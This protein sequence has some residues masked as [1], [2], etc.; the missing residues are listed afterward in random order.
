MID[1]LKGLPHLAIVPEMGRVHGRGGTREAEMLIFASFS[2]HAFRSWRG[3]HKHVTTPVRDSTRT[4]TVD[5]ARCVEVYMPCDVTKVTAIK[6]ESK[7]EAR[8]C[9][10]AERSAA[11]PGLGLSQPHIPYTMVHSS[12]SSPSAVAIFKFIN[13]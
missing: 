1:Y 5:T 11:I 8:A 10:A 3:Q 12:L 4:Q 7:A 6:S 2:R 13:V 9:R